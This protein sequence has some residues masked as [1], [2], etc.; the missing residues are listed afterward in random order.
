MTFDNTREQ[1]KY[2]MHVKEGQMVNIP[3]QEYF[4]MILMDFISFI[5]SE[6]AKDLSP[7]RR[8]GNHTDP[9]VRTSPGSIPRQADLYTI[10]FVCWVWV[11]VYACSFQDVKNLLIDIKRDLFKTKHVYYSKDSRTDI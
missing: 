4:E 5:S 2:V 3:T 8:N 7:T 9:I 10:T 6:D 11:F 1:T